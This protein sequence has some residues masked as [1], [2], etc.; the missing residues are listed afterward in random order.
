MFERVS[1]YLRGTV[2]KSDVLEKLR[3]HD[4]GLTEFRLFLIRDGEKAVL[5]DQDIKIICDALY[6]N[7]RVKS[8]D[9]SDS[10]IFS[11][12]TRITDV[13]A[14]Y[15]ARVLVRNRFINS[16]NLTGNHITDNGA[17]TIVRSLIYIL[18]TTVRDV[19]KIYLDNNQIS[20]AGAKEIA[21][22]IETYCY[23][24]PLVSVS[25]NKIGGEGI[26]AIY[27]AYLKTVIANKEKNF[28]NKLGF[29]N[30]DDFYSRMNSWLF[31][32]NPVGDKGIRIM[33]NFFK[34]F[35]EELSSMSSHGC[36]DLNFTGWG[37]TG[38]GVK[39]ITSI[40]KQ[41]N[42]K[43]KINLTKNRIGLEG[44][45]ILAQFLAQD[46]TVEAL[47][48][49]ECALGSAEI[50]LIAKSLEKHPTIR[51]VFFSNN[52]ND[53]DCGSALVDLLENNIYICLA[54][55]HNIEHQYS[56]KIDALLKRNKENQE[57]AAQAAAEKK[58]EAPPS[59][60]TTILNTLF[61][62]NPVPAMVSWGNYFTSFIP[63]RQTLL[64]L[65][66]RR[67]ASVPAAV[68]TDNSETPALT[69]LSNGTAAV[70][71]TTSRAQSSTNPAVGLT[72]ADNVNF[73]NTISN[74]IY[75]A[76]RGA[77]GITSYLILS[78]FSY[79]TINNHHREIGRNISN[80]DN[81][82]MISLDTVRQL[83]AIGMNIEEN[84]ALLFA[85]KTKQESL[86]LSILEWERKTEKDNIVQA[87]LEL[88][89]QYPEVKWYYHMMKS[90]LE[91]ALMAAI[92]IA[93]KEIP[94]N[95]GLAETV[96]GGLCTL[97]DTL[98]PM[99]APALG[100][101][102][103]TAGILGPT[104]TYLA[105]LR[106]LSWVELVEIPEFSA[107]LARRLALAQQ[108]K[109]I[110]GNTCI[111][112]STFERIK[113]HCSLLIEA[114][115]AGETLSDGEKLAILDAKR[116]FEYILTYDQ[117]FDMSL[118]GRVNLLVQQ[119][120]G[121]HY[122][123]TPPTIK[124]ST[125]Q[126]NSSTSSASASSTPAVST[127]I[128]EVALSSDLINQE[129][130]QLRQDLV[131]LKTEVADSKI[132]KQEHS[133]EL[134]ILQQRLET[135]D[136]KVSGTR[137]SGMC[138]NGDGTVSLQQLMVHSAEG[139]NVISRLQIQIERLENGLSMIGQAVVLLQEEQKFIP[140]NKK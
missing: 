106:R 36:L 120:L 114:L 119:L 113:D 53:N 56:S 68:V 3:K 70:T 88:I 64:S 76:R 26:K 112:K 101:I 99:I 98:F 104:L 2:L 138:D 69:T 110:A 43:N 67:N 94:T 79:A 115:Q 93:S 28:L 66:I 34:D 78:L 117:P 65:P 130:I 16:V 82:D 111:E 96:L 80:V 54:R 30:I 91:R 131:L 133:L 72:N 25:H 5:T 50:T 6:G 31:I 60:V 14:E 24:I 87:E 47:M 137:V 123:Y 41:I 33:M 105:M 40:L 38:E 108:A 95:T 134:Q 32:N 107:T 127:I 118:S 129:L 1:T 73:F 44:A 116:I 124:N 4:P 103:M 92:V 57:K 21:K 135:L 121:N 122:V 23:N 27:S 139:S 13:G 46:D 51:F 7:D 29:K 81:S 61:A 17:R 9:F 55:P 136:R 140:K 86:F 132:N 85:L 77:Y 97:A 48:L 42:K 52:K 83:T 10:A 75:A 22:F 71:F 74:A 126:K 90:I 49:S 39:E 128:T 18:G 19:C 58:S 15:I 20:D 45:Q 100:F 62:Y 8:L 102:K 37:L 35:K 11:P 63:S 109:I 125:M 12:A 89:A 84:R 59:R